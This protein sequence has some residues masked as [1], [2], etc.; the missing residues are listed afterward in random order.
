MAGEAALAGPEG[1]TPHETELSARDAG[2]EAE[3]GELLRQ[4]RRTVRLLV[5]EVP[6]PSKTRLPGRGRGEDRERGHAVRALPDVHP[7]ERAQGAAGP[8][9]A[10]PLDSGLDLGPHRLEEIEE[11]GLP[12]PGGRKGGRDVENG[13]GHEGGQGREVAERRGVGRDVETGGAVRAA[14]RDDVAALV[15]LRAG[16]E[17]RHRLA[18]ERDIGGRDGGRLE[19][20]ADP[21]RGERAGKKEGARELAARPS[22]Q[23]HRPAPDRAAETDGKPSPV[24]PHPRAQM[25][26]G[27]E[28]FAHRAFPKARA[29]VED[30]LGLPEGG[31]RESEAG[32]GP[33]RPE[34]DPCA[35]HE[36][37][38]PARSPHPPGS[39]PEVL[40][41][42]P[43]G[44]GK[45]PRRPEIVVVGKPPEKAR[46]LGH[47]REEERPVGDVLARR[48][49]RSEDPKGRG[50][51]EADTHG[52]AS[53]PGPYHKGTS[54]APVVRAAPTPFRPRAREPVRPL[55]CPSEGEARAMSDAVPS[56]SLL[57]TDYY[58]FTMLRTYLRTGKTD[59]AVFEFFV[60]PPLPAGRRFLVAAGLGDLVDVLLD[61]RVTPDECAWLA[62]EGF[63]D[64]EVRRFLEDL[65]FTGDIDAVPEG[66]V[67]FPDEP[68]V[69]VRAPLPLA[70]LVEARLINILHYQTLVA[71]KAARMRL[72]APAPRLLVDFG[73]RRAHGGEA[74][75]FLARAAYL[76]G[77]DG[78]ATVLAGRRYGIPLYGTMAHSFVLAYGDEN[79]AFLAYA[80]TH[81]EGVIFLI[82]TYDERAA[83]A[84]VARLRDRLAAEGVRV[85]GVRLDSG[86]LA[87]KARE[88]RTVL[89]AHGA[90]DVR[91]LVS[92][93]IDERG[94][95]ALHR[96]GA[97][98]DGFGVGTLLATSADVPYLNCA[99][100]L[101]A[102]ANEPKRKHSTGKATW[103]GAKQVFR[104]RGADGRWRGDT[105]GL[106][107][108]TLPGERLLVPVVR[109]GERLTPEEPLGHIRARCAH[110]I[111]ALPPEFLEIA[112]TSPPPA[113][114]VRPSPALR[115]LTA[116]LLPPPS[117]PPDGVP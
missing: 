116:S 57:L 42:G 53:G 101:V 102:Y 84:R 20:E 89:D 5:P 36:T 67:V 111:A 2:L 88:V 10:E 78:T 28:E 79:E 41:P 114:P 30:D 109:R 70:Q 117:P 19:N 22:A 45:R 29:S 47:G 66:T 95:D 105:V 40:E 77:F 21:V 63:H 75:V 83:A 35:R 104:T 68:L 55:C 26:E 9:D 59:E 56:S 87:E 76:A 8:A 25:R 51:R 15:L 81:P 37:G 46:A 58:A 17:R 14:A 13:S 49:R 23:A 12:P 38:P 18:G 7:P 91:I 44:L 73:L 31:E 106:E 34:I 71:S 32:K 60:R 99:Y 115:A 65:R 72:A 112:E 103:P 96:R 64:P 1:R 93:G 86:D 27:S 6:H 113:P 108:E 39:A 85:R 4:R 107:T 98:I 16:S 82:D 54:H 110:E 33:A 94:I 61:L 80:R 43:R 97:P 62:G 11:A 100:K 24:A 74:G 92:G 52:E 50:R 90:H 3:A 48:E 69:R